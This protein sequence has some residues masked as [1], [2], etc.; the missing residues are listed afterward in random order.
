MLAQYA[1]LQKPFFVWAVGVLGTLLLLDS[2]SRDF[3]SDKPKTEKLHSPLTATLQEIRSK[4]KKGQYTK[5]NIPVSNREG[6]FLWALLTCVLQSIVSENPI[7]SVLGKVIFLKTFWRPQPVFPRN[8]RSK[9]TLQDDGNE[10]CSDS[11]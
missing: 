9:T 8:I 11:N 7:P 1:D 3:A 5:A 10:R 2:H 4:H 6:R